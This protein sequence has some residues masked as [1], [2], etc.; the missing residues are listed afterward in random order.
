MYAQG[1]GQRSRDEIYETGKADL[2][3]VSMWLGD[4][5]FSWERLRRQSMRALI[6]FLPVISCLKSR[7]ADHGT[8]LANLWA[9]CGL[10]KKKYYET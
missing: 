5:P 6:H 9:Y 1:M 3:A 8:Y 2:A 10:M 7:A 4:K